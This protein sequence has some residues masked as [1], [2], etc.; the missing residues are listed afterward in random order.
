MLVSAFLITTLYVL[1]AL[2]LS[3]LL[4]R[5]RAGWRFRR[6][7]SDQENRSWWRLPKFSWSALLHTSQ[8]SS[9]SGGRVSDS[10]EMVKKEQDAGVAKVPQAK[11]GKVNFGSIDRT[12]FSSPIPNA[13]PPLQREPSDVRPVPANSQTT[14]KVLAM[15]MLCESSVTP[16]S[17][18]SLTIESFCTP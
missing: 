8:T 2:V 4:V 13:R 1:V 7:A 17:S 18:L 15:K 14:L 3:G 10:M 9:K 11:E 16:S 12:S 5:E 6:P